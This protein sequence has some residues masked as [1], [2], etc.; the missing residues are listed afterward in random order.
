M[1]REQNDSPDRAFD[2]LYASNIS[3]DRCPFLGLEEDASTALAYPHSANQCHRLAVPLEIDLIHQSGFCLSEYSSCDIY[4]QVSFIATEEAAGSKSEASSVRPA[5]PL[6]AFPMAI[7]SVKSALPTLYAS[8]RSQRAIGLLAPPLMLLLILFAAIVWWPPPGE[9][10]QD[11]VVAG[12]AT[13]QEDAGSADRPSARGQD[14]TDEISS[15]G[16]ASGPGKP[17]VLSADKGEQTAT[18]PALD[19]ERAV[20]QQPASAQASAPESQQT[21][22]ESPAEEDQEAVEGAAAPEG[23]ESITDGRARIGVQPL[24]NG[25]ASLP[26]AVIAAVGPGSETPSPQDIYESPPPLRLYRFPDEE[27]DLLGE[28]VSRQQA[29]IL[30]RSRGGEWLLI[31][32]AGGVEGWVNAQESGAAVDGLDL[33]VIDDGMPP[34]QEVALPEPA[35]AGAGSVT[36][37]AGDSPDAGPALEPG[38]ATINAAAVNLRAGPGLD[39]ESIGVGFNGEQITVLEDPGGSAWAQ[40][41]LA[42]GQ[43]GWMNRNYF[44]QTN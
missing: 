16:S 19:L 32:L 13:A 8:L 44:V 10:P 39:Y 1:A 28:I 17:Q 26:A 3:I 41:R 2:P 15:V 33:P 23:G 35:A 34:E 6:S 11:A 5:S 9:S 29:G 25:S 37:E 30:G 24:F 18:N 20:V 22:V 12:A 40:V 14:S 43:Q 4:G 31:R 36:E 42:N 21:R 7:A 27:G 38:S